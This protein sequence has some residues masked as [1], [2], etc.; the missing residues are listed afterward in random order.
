MEL[1]DKAEVLA[2]IKRRLHFDES[3]LEGDERWQERTGCKSSA[4][5]KRLG[6]K[7][8]GEAFLD[9][10]NALEVKAEIS[11]DEPVHYAASETKDVDD[12]AMQYNKVALM[13]GND[14]KMQAFKSGVHWNELRFLKILKE[15]QDIANQE[16]GCLALENLQL[17]LSELTR[18]DR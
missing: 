17:R 9:Y 6:S 15:L 14:S 18:E 1:I 8:T 12:V 5:Y 2:E 7:Q 10:V 3:W 16:D 13:T 11:V 4:Y